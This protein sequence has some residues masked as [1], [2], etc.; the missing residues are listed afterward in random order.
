[1]ERDQL[2]AKW[3]Q[4]KGKAKEFWG[5]LTGD[6]LD[7]IGGQREQLLGKLQEK[8]GMS[9]EEAERQVEQFTR[10]L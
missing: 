2:E 4:L 10:D 3:H 1:L 7:W 5:E 9:R 8:Y 6:E